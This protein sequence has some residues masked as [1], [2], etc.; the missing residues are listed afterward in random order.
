MKFSKSKSNFMH[1]QV[2]G[3]S[4]ILNPN[5]FELN[6]LSLDFLNLGFLFHFFL[7]MCAEG[8]FSVVYSICF[9]STFLNV[10]I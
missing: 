9:T 4:F 6:I 3:S 2:K 7:K 1:D 10:W 5:Y 8:H